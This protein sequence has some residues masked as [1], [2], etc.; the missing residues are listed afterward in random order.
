MINS[1][2]GSLAAAVHTVTVALLG[3]C[4]ITGVLRVRRGPL[5]RYLAITAVLTLVVIGGARFVFAQLLQ[6]EYTRDKVL[7][8]MHLLHEPAP[9]TVLKIRPQP[10]VQIRV[11][12][13]RGCASAAC[14]ASATCPTRPPSR[15]STRKGDL[16]GLDIELAHRLATEL[17][18]RLE[19]VPVERNDLARSDLGRLLR[20][21]HGRRGGHH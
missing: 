8:G 12:F 19:F 6:Q 3:T 10:T 5:L 21:R 17:H 9:A 20:S 4:A 11:R 7:V 13:S 16:V 14:C 15:S 2:V 18:V 1:R